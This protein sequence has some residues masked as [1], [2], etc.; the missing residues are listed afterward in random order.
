[1]SLKKLTIAGNVVLTPLFLKEFEKTSVPAEIKNLLSKIHK[2]KIEISDEIFVINK[3]GY[4]G[5]S[6]KSE[7][8][9]AQTLCK[10]IVYLEN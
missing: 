8:K 2:R 6:T 7:I 1:M 3:G 4:I 5:E 9:Y 10:K